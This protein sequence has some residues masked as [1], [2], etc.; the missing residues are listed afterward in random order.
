MKNIITIGLLIGCVFFGKAQSEADKWLKVVSAQQGIAIEWQE[1]K[2]SLASEGI[3]SF[4]GYYQDN[5]VATLSVGGQSV[6]GSFHYRDTSYEINEQKGQLVF[7]PN[8]DFRCGTT[9]TP[10]S[11]PSPSTARPAILAEETTPTIANTQTLRVYRLAMHIPYSTFSTEHLGKN[12]QKVKTFW[13]DTENFLNEV[14]LR[15]LGVRFEL[16]NDERLIIKDESKETFASFHNAD[17]VKD[18]STKVI[19]GLIGENSYDVGISLAYTASLNKGV[20]GLAYLKGV[21]QANTKADA[22]AV[23]T[24][25]VIAHE[26]GHLFG[27]KHTFGSYKGS[28]AYDSE[29]T[30]YDRGTS[31]MSYGSPRDFFSLSSIQRIRELLTKVPVKAHDKTFTTQAPRIDHSKIKNHYTIPKGTFFQFYIPAIDPDSAELL[32]SVN[33]HDVRNGAESPITQYIIYKPTPANPV[34]IKTEYHKDSGSVIANSGLAQQTTGTFTF[35]LGVS[36]APLQPS[37]DYIVQ[38]DLAETK[39]TV[40]E[41][42]PFKITNTL[43]SEYKGGAQLTLSWN[44]DNTIFKDTKVRIL[45]SDDLGKT[46]KH[47]V[48]AEADNNGSKEIILP[49]I[50]TTQAVLKVEVIDGL[51]FDLTNYNPK[52]GGFT[53]EK[54]PALPEPLLWASLPNHLTLSCEQSIPAVV[55]PTVTGG[56]TPA[57]TLQ[58]EERIK[59]N[60]DYTY[61]VKRIFTAADT[62]NQTLTYTQTISVTDKT[63]PTFVGALP[64]NMSVKEGKTIPAQVTLTA[65]DNCGTAAVTTSHKEEKDAKG[66]LTKLIYTWIAKDTCG[67]VT[68]HQQIVTIVPKKVPTLTWATLPRDITVDCVKAIPAVQTPTTQGGCAKVV[69]TRADKEL[70]KRCLNNFT[71]ERTFT[72]SDGCATLTHTQRI[73]V[74]DKKS[75][76]FVGTL[77]Q[78]LTIDEGTPIPSQQ[79]ISAEDACAGQPTVTMPPKEEYLTN[80]KLSKVVY[81]WV[82]RDVCGNERIHTQNI[83]IKL[84]SQEPPHIDTNPDE[85]VIY[86]AVSTEKGFDNYFRIENT[87]KNQPITLVIFDEMGLKVYENNHY[88]Q[89]GEYFRGYPNIKGVVGSKRLAGTYFYVLTYYFNGQQQ[90]K[91]GFLYVR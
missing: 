79:S 20:R 37:A 51:A 31:V 63:P 57:V 25:E 74:S 67:N 10:H 32:Y 53:I 86:N 89:N 60:C 73:K 28:E 41:G 65:T 54:N 45:L 21:Y 84:K 64:Q 39:V 52:N 16:V 83:T 2:T 27:G 59:G 35:W 49:N 11:H 66:K 71:L 75:P 85:V 30:E 77:P 43:K 24:K 29:K 58:K 12:I 13:A 26:I 48:V 33:Q 17:Y 4:V 91:K 36:D 76:T 61:T 72:A 19:N 38:Y 14:Y 70:N 9:D 6:S 55:L 42:I 69:I 90:T 23:L 46:F 18:H 3:R 47:M 87:D 62:C 88:Q 78:D 50:S 82:A 44:V 22:V 7:S 68:T 81:K 40:K 34:T 80:G 15:D 5:F 56:C 1:R 8:K